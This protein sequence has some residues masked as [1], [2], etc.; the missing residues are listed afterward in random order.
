MFCLSRQW[1]RDPVLVWGA[2]KQK[3]W[4]EDTDPTLVVGKKGR[5]PLLH[6]GEEEEQEEEEEEEEEEGG[7][8]LPH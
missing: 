3:G 1:G 4:P 2:A 5:L 8:V 6:R 7:P